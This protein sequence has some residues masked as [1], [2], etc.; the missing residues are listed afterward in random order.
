MPKG[1]NERMNCG[2][3][4][5]NAQ[6]GRGASAFH[7]FNGP[8][9]E[10]PCHDAYGARKL[11]DH[12]DAVRRQN[13]CRQRLLDDPLASNA[14]ADVRSSGQTS[15]AVEVIAGHLN[16]PGKRKRNRIRVTSAEEVARAVAAARDGD[17]GCSVATCGQTQRVLQGPLRL[18]QCWRKEDELDTCMFQDGRL[19]HDAQGC[20]GIAARDIGASERSCNTLAGDVST[21]DTMARL[22]LNAAGG[23]GQ[24]KRMRVGNCPPTSSVA[25]S[26]LQEVNASHLGTVQWGCSPIN[27]GLMESMVGSKTA[28]DSRSYWPQQLHG[29]NT[30][31]Q[32]GL[33]TKKRTPLHVLDEDWGSLNE[34]RGA[35]RVQV[36]FL[37]ERS[38][39]MTMP[40]CLKQEGASAHAQ[41]L[42]SSM[43]HEEAN[44]QRGPWEQPQGL[45]MSRGG[46]VAFAVLEGL[47]QGGRV[48]GGSSRA[49][50]VLT[51]SQHH[52]TSP[53]SVDHAQV[54]SWFVEDERATGGQEEHLN[55]HGCVEGGVE[56]C[57][58]PKVTREMMTSGQSTNQQQS[59]EPFQVVYS[60]PDAEDVVLLQQHSDF[61]SDHL[62]LTSSAGLHPSWL[63]GGAMEKEI[64]GGD[65]SVVIYNKLWGQCEGRFSAKEEMTAADLCS[66]SATETH[67][68][69]SG[70]SR[71][72]PRSSSQS[73]S[74][75]GRMK[76]EPRICEEAA[77]AAYEHDGWRNNHARPGSKYNPVIIDD[78]DCEPCNYNKQPACARV[79]DPQEDAGRESSQGE[80]SAVTTKV[81]LGLTSR[82]LH[83]EPCSSPPRVSENLASRVLNADFKEL[84][85]RGDLKQERISSLS[86]Q[87][88]I[89]CRYAN[90]VD[91]TQEESDSQAHQNPSPSLL[92]CASSPLSPSAAGSQQLKRSG[93]NYTGVWSASAPSPICPDAAAAESEGLNRLDLSG[94]GLRSTTSPTCF[95]PDGAE[96]QVLKRSDVAERGGVQPLSAASPVYRDAEESQGLSWLDVSEAGILSPST[97]SPLPPDPDGSHCL[98]RLQVSKAGLRSPSSPSPFHSHG[99]ESQG[100]KSFDAREPGGVRPLSSAPSP[101]CP[102]VL[103]SQGLDRLD[104]SEAGLPSSPATPSRFPLD[105]AES[106]AECQ[107]L[108]KPDGSEPSVKSSPLPSSFPPDTV[109]S[110]GFSRPRVKSSPN[111]APLPSDAAEVKGLKRLDVTAELRVKSSPASFPFHPDAV[112]STGVKRSE[113]CESQVQSSPACSP[114]CRDASETPMLKRSDTSE[115]SVLFPLTPTLFRSDPDDSLVLKR[116]DTRDAN[117]ASQ[118]ECKGE[119]AFSKAVNSECNVEDGNE[120]G[121]VD[122]TSCSDSPS[123]KKPAASLV[124]KP[125]L[126]NMG[127]EAKND[128]S[129][130]SASARGKPAME[131]RFAEKERAH[132][133]ADRIARLGQQRYSG[134]LQSLFAEFEQLTSTPGLVMSA[135]DLLTNFCRAAPEKFFVALY[136]VGHKDWISFGRAALD[137]KAKLHVQAPSDRRKGAFPRG[138]RKG[139]ATFAHARSASAS[140]SDS[141]ADTPSAGIGSAAET[142]V[143][144]ALTQAV[145]GVLQQQK[146]FSPTTASASPKGKDKG[147]APPVS[148]PPE[149]QQA[150]DQ[151]A[152]LMKEPFGLRNRPTKHHIEL[153]PGAVPPRGRIYRMS[154]A[155]LEELRKQF[156]TLTNKGWIRPSTYEFGAPVLFVPKG[157]GEFKM[158][159][160]YRGLNKIA[161]STEPLPRIDDL[162]DMVQGCTMFNKVDLKFGYHQ[163]EMA[164][165]DVYKTT[166]KTS[167]GT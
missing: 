26:R 16:S 47:N 114:C 141:Q 49:D 115:S 69:N 100:L 102:A 122:P 21:A 154:P 32:A 101:I 68:V 54:R 78:D 9:V 10:G 65:M 149:I 85:W 107:G 7:L 11:C 63:N 142:D 22:T 96:S 132:K 72:S 73:G 62:C 1:S 126:S 35:E 12:C 81:G 118:L 6:R 113:V 160:N 55:R 145:L 91:L 95:G 93:V 57:P 108:Q 15:A 143:A 18:A 105:A 120:A 41:V 28:G 153:L 119:P 140:D 157:N 67:Q 2:I 125:S 134:A 94:A 99:A 31:V 167:Y 77:T 133:A 129:A 80:L 139:K 82:P 14:A 152:D 111:P 110:Q 42:P 79:G 66:M 43:P 147:H 83:S 5:G 48:Q 137:M 23:G 148:R 124:S 13:G 162:L 19:W 155:E 71:R 56:M 104:V 106:A 58:S 164:E 25:V 159:I 33:F 117:I 84:G 146:R 103:E 64:E 34:G 75:D 37:S 92:P 27:G 17:G 87:A 123:A 121:N 52:Q 116:V 36:Q 76:K 150:V 158:C 138:G 51:S 109:D 29:C 156:E 130:S 128:W 39:G 61:L 30:T 70:L 59:E 163:I 90:F 151:Y 46:E 4:I 97:P 144:A 166:F 50:A 45:S 127:E 60:M 135:G 53:V 161:R 131:D 20:G 112:E 38:G 98:N 165:E 88:K 40:E 24:A 136:S 86:P 8:A 89:R 44:W 74:N 3:G